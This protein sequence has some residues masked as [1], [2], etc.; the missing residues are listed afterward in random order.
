MK[1]LLCTGLWELKKEGGGRGEK[2]E[3]QK[4]KEKES[5]PVFRAWMAEE[6]RAHSG[7]VARQ[8]VG[9]GPSG[10]GAAEEWQTE[11]V[12]M[13]ESCISWAP[14]PR[15]VQ[16][17]SVHR[18]STC[19]VGVPSCYRPHFFT[20]ASTLSPG[21][22]CKS[23]ALKSYLQGLLRRLNGSIHYPN[24]NSRHLSRP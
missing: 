17:G 10:G 20:S 23:E 6:A 4:I 15:P 9:A 1:S 16:S 12:P 18:E 14:A 8:P 3:S 7:V 11:I 19:P 2:R 13:L 21:P 24:K 5:E 22:P